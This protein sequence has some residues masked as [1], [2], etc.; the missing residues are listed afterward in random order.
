ML[1][2]KGQIQRLLEIRLK[3]NFTHLNFLQELK[4][5]LLEK[6][7]EKLEVL[8]LKDKI[9][10]LIGTFKLDLMIIIQVHYFIKK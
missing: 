6:I 8:V 7:M 4:K 5:P 1:L 10:L 2:K 9:Q 3:Q